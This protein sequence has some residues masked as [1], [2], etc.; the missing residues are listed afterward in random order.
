MAVLPDCAW[1][2][3]GRSGC[4]GHAWLCSEGH[5]CSLQFLVA[6]F[7][8]GDKAVTSAF[9]ARLGFSHP[10]RPRAAENGMTEA[11]HSDRFD[12]CPSHR[13]DGSAVSYWFY[14][15]DAAGRMSGFDA[16]GEDSVG[17]LVVPVVEDV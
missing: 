13:G 12:I 7:G 5:S 15:E 10:H 6:R 2:P 16:S 1:R 17:V 8:N 11:E 14:Y 9:A 4:C 3:T